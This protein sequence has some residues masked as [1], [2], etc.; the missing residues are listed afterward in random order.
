[1]GRRGKR[2][3][4][5]LEDLKGTRR[6]WRLKEEALDRSVWRIGFGRGCASSVTL[7][8]FSNSPVGGGR[9]ESALSNKRAEGK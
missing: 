2:S 9:V 8:W 6:Q 3:K 7:A 4:Q 5:L 1:M